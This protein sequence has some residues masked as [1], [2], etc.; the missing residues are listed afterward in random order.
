MKATDF[1][2]ARLAFQTDVSD[3]HAALSTAT[4]RLV[5]T[6]ST[7][8]WTQAH[9]PG[10]IRLADL[11]ADDGTPV[12]TYCWGPGC[13]GATK[14]ALALARRGYAVRE[15]LGGIE[16]W[17][18]EG[19][20]V[21]TP[22]GESRRTPDPL[23]VPTLTPPSPARPSATSAA[24]GM[25]VGVAPPS[26]TSAAHGM[27]VSVAP[28]SPTSAAADGAGAGAVTAC[29]VRAGAAAAGAGS[30]RAGAAVGSVAAEDV[31]VGSVAAGGVAV[32]SVV[33]VDE[34]GPLPGPACG[35]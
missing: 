7:Q 4:V 26:A 8:A 12:V 28:P 20:P 32:G 6:R 9:I 24:R 29:G 11:P 18:R 23:T 17:I 10:A 21:V 13:N 22:T 27:D 33:V 15:M 19:F 35:C 5:D 31:A 14:A 1:F 25:D 34:V 16:Y 2:A 30:M 3:V